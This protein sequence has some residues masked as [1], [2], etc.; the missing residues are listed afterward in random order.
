MNCDY[1]IASKVIVSRMK[2]VLLSIM[3]GDQTGFLK[4]RFI[5]ENIRL[6]MVLLQMQAKRTFSGCLLLFISKKLFYRLN[7]PL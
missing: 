3:K 2:K 7:G 1:K 6:I 4:Q 5:D